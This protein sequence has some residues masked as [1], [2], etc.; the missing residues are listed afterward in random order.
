MQAGVHK[1]CMSGLLPVRCIKRSRFRNLTSSRRCLNMIGLNSFCDCI[2]ACLTRANGG[3]PATQQVVIICLTIPNAPE[4]CDGGGHDMCILA[5]K[6]PLQ[7]SPVTS[8]SHREQL[9]LSQSWEFKEVVQHN[10]VQIH[11]QLQA[12][13]PNLASWAT[14]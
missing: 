11:L 9:I 14:F 1:D 13:M 8:P 7:P 3:I 10:L 5:S 2:I 6:L 12:S 4:R